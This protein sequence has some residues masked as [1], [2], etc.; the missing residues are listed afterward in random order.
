MVKH[1]ELLLWPVLPRGNSPSTILDSWPQTLCHQS[2]WS[3]SAS[4]SASPPV[5]SEKDTTCPCELHLL[6]GSIRGGSV[7]QTNH[8]Q[9]EV[10]EAP[11]AETGTETA[12]PRC[13]TSRSSCSL[14]LWL[15]QDLRRLVEEKRFVKDQEEV[16][17]ST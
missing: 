1:V 6:T 4:G 11:P 7:S 2:A 13:G 16:S 8:S 12:Q 17:T 5:G 9:Q 10:N 14:A 3:Q 15:A